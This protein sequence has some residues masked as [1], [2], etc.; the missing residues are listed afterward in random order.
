MIYSWYQ[1]WQACVVFV[2]RKSVE[3]QK[4]TKPKLII[5]R[6]FVSQSYTRI[7]R[8]EHPEWLNLQHKCISRMEKLKNRLFTLNSPSCV[9][10]SNFVRGWWRWIQF[11]VS[12]LW[13]TEENSRYSYF[14]PR[15]WAF[16]SDV[17]VCLNNG[18]PVY[19]TAQ[20]L[21]YF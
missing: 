21:I 5:I 13:I 8:F 11:S 3:F 14:F 16:E 20:K 1:L 15:T 17:K 2:F 9:L 10:T 12:I 6:F 19:D 4:W 18:N 7:F